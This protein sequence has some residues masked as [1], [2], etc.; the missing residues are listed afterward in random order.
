MTSSV[1]L[2]DK[3]KRELSNDVS[4]DRAKH[5]AKPT[6]GEVIVFL[7]LTNPGAQTLFAYCI[8]L[9]ISSLYFASLYQ[10]HYRP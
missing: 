5:E 1:Q 8:S 2:H 4:I 10:S 9:H 7:D 6:K 3:E